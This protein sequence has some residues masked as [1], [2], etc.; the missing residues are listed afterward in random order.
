MALAGFFDMVNQD[1]L[2]SRISR[3]VKDKR[4]LGLISRYLRA[5]VVNKGCP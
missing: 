4:V 1:V 3:K 2:M 5:G